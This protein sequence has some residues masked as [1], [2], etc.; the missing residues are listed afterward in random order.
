MHAANKRSVAEGYSK[1]IV[2]PTSAKLARF[3]TDPP[4]N[5]TR[6]VGLTSIHLD[7]IRSSKKL[8]ARRHK[9]EVH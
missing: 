6:L 4:L 2:R 5:E 3:G 1:D 7:E 9:Y 8:P